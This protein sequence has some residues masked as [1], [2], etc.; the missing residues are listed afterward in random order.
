MHLTNNWQ[1]H[2]K[3]ETKWF[4][5]QVPG[6]LV[7][8]L[9]ANKLIADPYFSQNAESLDW[10]GDCEWEYATHFDVPLNVLKNEN[11]SLNFDGL[12]TYAEVFLNDTLILKPRQHVQSVGGFVQA[13]HQA[14][15]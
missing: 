9:V 6:D 12:D 3:G 4:D 2:K 14:A 13:Q 15:Q 8:D 5:A 10:I 11:I 1:F 7:S